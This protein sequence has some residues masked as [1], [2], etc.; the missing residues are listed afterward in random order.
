LVFSRQ[1]SF[2]YFISAADLSI[3]ALCL[4]SA[5]DVFEIF[6]KNSFLLLTVALIN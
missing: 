5:N 1:T 6:K 3:G 2:G 4:G